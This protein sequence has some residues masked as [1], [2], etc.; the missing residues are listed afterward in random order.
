MSSASE[1]VE[2]AKQNQMNER[3]LYETKRRINCISV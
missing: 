2:I 1:R 3:K